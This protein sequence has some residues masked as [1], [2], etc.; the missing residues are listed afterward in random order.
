MKCEHCGREAA[1]GVVL[2]LRAANSRQEMHGNRMMQI[3]QDFAPFTMFFCRACVE[4][5]KK[6]TATGKLVLSGIILGLAA[7]LMVISALAAKPQPSAY[8]ILAVIFGGLWAGTMFILNRNLQEVDRLF[9]LEVG[10]RVRSL[11]RNS[12]SNGR[13]WQDVIPGKAR[14]QSR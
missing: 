13:Y 3:R 8:V 10:N 7:A 5:G 14:S 11:E 1:D 2:E 12:Y 4:A 9:P 6:R